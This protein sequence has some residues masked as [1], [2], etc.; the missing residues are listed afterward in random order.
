M[1][2]IKKI[3]IST[4]ILF[5]AIFAIIDLPTTADVGDFESYDS[6]SWSSSDWDS[7]SWDYDS[8]WGSSSGGF[9]YFGGGFG[10]FIV[11][12]I[13]MIIITV[14]TSKY[15]KTHKRDYAARNEMLN[16]TQKGQSK[17]EIEKM[18]DK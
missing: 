8:D 15:N 2:K 11:F 17:E 18:K 16:N 4:F 14:I 13:V 5:V 9:Y 10:G 6:S 12:L 3:I 1:Q 7:S